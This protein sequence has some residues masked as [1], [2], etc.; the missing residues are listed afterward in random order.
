MAGVETIWELHTLIVMNSWFKI[1]LKMQLMFFC[2]LCNT[3]NSPM[4]KLC[5]TIQRTVLLL[6]SGGGQAVFIFL[7]LLFFRQRRRWALRN[8]GKTLVLKWLHQ[9]IFLVRG[10]ETD[11]KST[12]ACDFTSWVCHSI[13]YV[14]HASLLVKSLQD[15]KNS[16]PFLVWGWGLAYDH[17]TILTCSPLRWD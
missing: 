7:L 11:L 17:L 1:I 14:G 12:S 8:L 15:P 10:C 6:F 13:G 5:A 3:W 16:R 4:C 2:V 9:T